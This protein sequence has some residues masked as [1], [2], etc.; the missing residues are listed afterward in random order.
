MYRQ[1]FEDPF[2]DLLKTHLRMFDENEQGIAG[3][4]GID[5]EKGKALCEIF[6]SCA[7]YENRLWDALYDF[8]PDGGIRNAE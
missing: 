1:V 2:L 8:G 3:Q 7:G 6:V 4:L 5:G